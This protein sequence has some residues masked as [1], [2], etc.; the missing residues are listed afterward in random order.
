[1]LIPNKCSLL[2]FLWLL[3]IIG[4]LSSR[5][6]SWG[7]G[8][9]SG[10]FYSNRINDQWSTILFEETSCHWPPP[11]HDRV[12]LLKI[13]DVQNIWPSFSS[14]S[15]LVFLVKHNKFAILPMARDK[16]SAAWVLRPGNVR[17]L[18]SSMYQ[19]SALCSADSLFTSEKIN[20]ISLWRIRLPFL[21]RLTRSFCSLFVPR[22]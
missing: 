2:S 4:S 21:I 11:L 5:T 8:G 12:V 14:W 19:C 18:Y 10:N 15:S 9:H 22:D 16:P 17:K 7:G 6:R 13:P 20:E 3:L 1:M